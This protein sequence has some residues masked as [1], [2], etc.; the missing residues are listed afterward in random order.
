MIGLDAIHN[1]HILIVDDHQANIDALAGLLAVNGYRRISC[2]TDGRAVPAMHAANGYDVILLDMHM[3]DMGGME[4]MKR[5]QQ[6]DPDH[7]LPVI[8]LTGD[9]HS[10]IAAL[11]AGA[12]DFIMKPYDFA[13]LDARIRNTLEVRLLYKA[14]DENRRLQQQQAQHDVLTGLP[15][16]RLLT[17]RLANS[18]ELCRR[19]HRQMALLY[20]DL[21]GFKE[22]NDSHGHARGDLLLMHVA[23][24]IR[25]VV[26]SEDTVARIGGDEFII[27]L[28]EIADIADATRPAMELLRMLEAPFALSD[29][30]VQ[31]SASIGIAFFPA[32]AI[33]AESLIAVADEALYNAKRAGKNRYEFA[34]PLTR[35]PQTNIALKQHIDETISMVK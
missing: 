34:G 23:E 16:R 1:G 7:Y 26:R 19:R 6:A 14:V 11:A 8:V 17:E 35:Q 33:E 5:L 22:V 3:P 4:V 20:M 29:A 21:D 9:Q 30:L 10:R 12:R 32:D 31:I 2:T 13:E 27:L 25:S 24:R 28:P 15:N 18:M